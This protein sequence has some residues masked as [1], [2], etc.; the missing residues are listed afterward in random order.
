MARRLTSTTHLR[1]RIIAASIVLAV[2][3]I[4][5]TFGYWILADRAYSLLDCAY[6]SV[7][8]I[9]TVGF[10]EVVDLSDNPAGRVFTIVVAVAGAVDTG[11]D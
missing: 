5:G 10:G 2:V 1:D 9:T 3:L 4:G 7:I 6:M 11:E 8:T